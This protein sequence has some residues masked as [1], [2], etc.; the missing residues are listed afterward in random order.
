MNISSKQPIWLVQLVF[1]AHS[2]C[3]YLSVFSH[4]EPRC[5]IGERL[6]LD[7]TYVNDI[8][9][10]FEQPFIDCVKLA[11]IWVI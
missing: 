3:L 8:A 2:V 4:R 6:T 9:L 11:N 5:R 7:Y 10:K 1:N